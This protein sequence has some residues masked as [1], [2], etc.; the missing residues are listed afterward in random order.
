MPARSNKQRRRGRQPSP[1]DCG[2]A[3]SST[4]SASSVDAAPMDQNL[5]DWWAFAESE[6]ELSVPSRVEPKLS[7]KA[8]KK[9]KRALA[10]AEAAAAEQADDAATDED[11]EVSNTEAP[12]GFAGVASA[13]VCV[14]SEELHIVAAVLV[15]ASYI[16]GS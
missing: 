11:D 3:G 16:A 8:K 4:S 15:V 9:A 2:S 10:A 13:C 5:I 7:A 14:W 12:S 1:D 6:S